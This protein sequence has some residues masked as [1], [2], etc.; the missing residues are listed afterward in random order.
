MAQFPTLNLFHLEFLKG[1]YWAYVVKNCN[2]QLYADDTLI[3]FSSNSITTIE[4]ILSED[5]NHIIE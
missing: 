3:Y 1:Q 5:L 4:S 2:I